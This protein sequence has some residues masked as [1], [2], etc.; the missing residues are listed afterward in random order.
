MMEMQKLFGQKPIHFGL[1]LSFVMNRPGMSFQD[2]TLL[3]GLGKSTVPRIID[4]F[5][6]EGMMEAYEI[7]DDRRRKYVR[8]TEKGE[9]LT[10]GLRKLSY[11]Y[12]DP[13]LNP[14]DE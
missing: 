12:K 11:G 9:R 14:L 6:D 3:S 1:I 8:L 4:W 10:F 5:V 2:I 7:P 13:P